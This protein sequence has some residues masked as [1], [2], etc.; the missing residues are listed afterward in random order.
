MLK[1]MREQLEFIKFISERLE[2]AEIPY[3]LTGSVALAVYT[4]P[5]MTRDIDLVIEC[6]PADAEMILRLFETECYLDAHGPAAFTEL[7]AAPD[8]CEDTK[9]HTLSDFLPSSALAIFS[10]S[11]AKSKGF[12]M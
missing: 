4:E 11:S 1:W 8:P 12:A 2:S 10:L 7:I 5:R 3:M 6:E 9:H